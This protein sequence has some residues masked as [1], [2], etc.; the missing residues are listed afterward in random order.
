MI[1]LELM[2][3]F[4]L[5]PP[6]AGMLAGAASALG[7]GAA[8]GLA[9]GAMALNLLLGT[10][11]A[12]LLNGASNVLNQIFDLPIDR[13]NKPARPLPSKRVAP[14]AAGRFCVLLYATSLI[15]AYG[16][17]PAGRPEV[18]WIV[19][20]TAL[21]T[22]AYSSPP[23]RLRRSWWLAPLVI[24]IPRGG[25]LKVA[26]W[27]VAAPVFSDSEPWILGALFFLFVLGAAS[28]KD[29]ADVEGD[30]R[31]GVVTLPARFGP[32]R[33]AWL[34]APFYVLPWAGLVLLAIPGVWSSP[35][36]RVDPRAG[37]ATGVALAIAGALVAAGMVRDAERL[38]EREAGAW[39]WRR[40]YI[41][42][43]A[44]Q[45]GTACLY[46]LFPAPS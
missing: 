22:W 13:I 46:L 35:P 29:F 23:L 36:L 45:A 12:V 20:F 14:A 3:P 39:A 44:A 2:R 18:F 38:R 40:L 9:T 33:A 42:M 34:M 37:V 25:L 6:L 11:M 17:Q 21:L 15:L 19:A 24:A 1:W 28:T 41:L 8:S 32:K 4:T 5:L 30:A 31:A 26:G 7:A 43:M 27:G 16:I 10:L